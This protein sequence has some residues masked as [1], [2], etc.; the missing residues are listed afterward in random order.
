MPYETQEFTWVDAKKEPPPVWRDN[1]SKPVLCYDFEQDVCVVG[2]FDY[3]LNEWSTND[4]ALYSVDY[5][6][7][8]QKPRKY[9]S[10]V[11]LIS[12]GLYPDRKQKN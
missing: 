3:E 7:F 8:I 2:W 1:F 9:W 6:A 10:R 4:E 11:R 5:W 12:E